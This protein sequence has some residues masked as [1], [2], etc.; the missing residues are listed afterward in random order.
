[1]SELLLVED[2]NDNAPVFEANYTINV[3]ENS[4]T[5]IRLL[6]V[7]ADDADK[8]INGIVVFSVQKIEA[9]TAAAVPS[10]L[11]AISSTG[12]LT[13]ENDLDFEVAQE[14]FITVIAKDS[15]TPYLNSS[16]VVT[17]IVED[18]QDSPPAF[19]NSS[20]DTSISE[21]TPEVRL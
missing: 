3:T 12:W 2:V 15:G 18:L 5:G 17:V 4:S 19:S 10:N 11:F 6:K 20:Y 9:N 7:I 21:T 16:T 8:G 13:L 14:Y 1:M